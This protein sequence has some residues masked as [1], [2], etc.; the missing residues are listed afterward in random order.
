VVEIDPAVTQVVYDELGLPPDTSIKT[1]NEDA[2]RFLIER[3]TGDKYDVVIGD[4]FNDLSTPYHLTTLEFN[5]LVKAHMEE[6]GIYLVNINDYPHGRYMP[7]FIH[8]IRQTFKYVY[9]FSVGESWER[10]T[11]G[12]LVNTAYDRVIVATDYRIDLTDYRKFVTE[13]GR[14]KASG[15]PLDEDQLEKYLANRDPILLTDEHAPTD[16]L[17]APIFQ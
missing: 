2:R 12:T 15:F 4:V 3:K 17:I 6:D 14:N 11:D 5:N 9:L 10:L 1:Y 7:S 16:I 13:G 8:T